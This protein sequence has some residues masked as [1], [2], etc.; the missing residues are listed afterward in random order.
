MLA[1]E[2]D[3]LPDLL[4]LRRAVAPVPELASRYTWRSP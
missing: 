4:G 2:L 1:R 3:A